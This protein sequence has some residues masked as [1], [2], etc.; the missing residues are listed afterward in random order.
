M[1][2]DSRKE[3]YAHCTDP[4]CLWHKNRDQLPVWTVD[5]DVY[6]KRPSLVI[7]T[8]DK[9]AQIARNA[10]TVSLFGNDGVNRQPDLI[11]QD[12]LHLISGPLGTLAGLYEVAIDRL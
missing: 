4:D 9:F 2:D 6:E 8:I 12:E 11:I 5:E 10:N 3:I 1:T 7:G